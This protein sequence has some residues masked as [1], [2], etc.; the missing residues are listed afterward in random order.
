MAKSVTAK[1]K[2]QKGLKCAGSVCFDEDGNIVVKLN[3]KTCPQEVVEGLVK[4]TFK[5]KEVVFDLSKDKE[6]LMV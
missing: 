2:G 4:A 6:K 1:P 3:E 5:G